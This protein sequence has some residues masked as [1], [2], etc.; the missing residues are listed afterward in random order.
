LAT[1]LVLQN[2][3]DISRQ[4]VELMSVRPRQGFF[5]I[6]ESGVEVADKRVK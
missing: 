1:G 6:C 2:G 3:S 5:D 4:A